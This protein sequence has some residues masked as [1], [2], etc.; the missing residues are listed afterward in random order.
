KPFAN[1]TLSEA[2]FPLFTVSVRGRCSKQ[3]QRSDTSW[4]QLVFHD[5]RSSFV[6]YHFTGF[7]IVTTISLS[8]NRQ[9]RLFML[10]C[11]LRS[12][13]WMRENL[14]KATS[15]PANGECRRR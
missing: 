8:S 7:V 9:H 11:M 10:V 3:R 14:P 2:C 12:P 15:F 5:R 6:R 4:E 1:V 13:D